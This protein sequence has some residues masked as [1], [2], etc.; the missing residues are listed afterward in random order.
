MDGFSDSEVHSLISNLLDMNER[1][2]ISF[3]NKQ[4]Y[5]NFRKDMIQYL[6]KIFSSLIPNF[7]NNL[8]IFYLSVLYLDIICSKNRIS[9]KNETNRKM[10]VL[11]SFIIS[12]KFIGNYDI[13]ELIIKKIIKKEFL[14]FT[15]FEARCM[16]LLD[17]NLIFSTVFDIL[18]MILYDSNPKI[19]YTCKSI[20]Y[21]FIENES[22][23]NYN[24]F[25][26]A[27]SIYKY[28]RHI[29]G[30]NNKNYYNKFFDLKQ[31][32]E[33][34]NIIQYE[35][36]EINNSNSG[37]NSSEED[38]QTMSS[39]MDERKYKNSF[40]N[41]KKIFCQKICFNE[42]QN[43]VNNSPIQYPKNNNLINS[44]SFLYSTKRNNSSNNLLKNE[45]KNEFNTITKRLKNNGINKIGISLKNVSNL[46]FEKL[47]KLSIRYMKTEK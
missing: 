21:S 30:I 46:P 7:E 35:F 32:E 23:I 37:N 29:T 39:T 20:L 12:L 17:Y 24:A 15:N 36:F 44:N 10:I 26:I 34:E 33:I 18:N 22:F 9:I 47:A 5:L 27:I 28:S 38:M 43:Q 40:L 25:S 19:L 3:S 16:Y 31:I 13:I 4:H 2:F 1:N 41:S 42:K 45:I 8:N 11:T 6:K 14:N